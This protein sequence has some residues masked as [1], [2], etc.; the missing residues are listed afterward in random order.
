MTE[1][2]H[3]NDLLKEIAPLLKKMDQLEKR[4]EGIDKTIS[5]QEGKKTK[6]IGELISCSLR[7][8]QV[9]RAADALTTK[10]YGVDEWRDWPWV[11]DAKIA[12]KVP[13]RERK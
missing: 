6:I 7:V 3:P 5:M 11:K 1:P 12:D 13:P 10:A 4:R 9:T 8:E 2:V